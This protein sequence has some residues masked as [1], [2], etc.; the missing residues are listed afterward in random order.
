M[1][2]EAG[3]P[4]GE[5]AAAPRPSDPHRRVRQPGPA[6]AER[7]DSVEGVAERFEVDLPAG[8]NLIEAIRS[9]LERTS[10]TSAVLQLR[11]GGF[12]P[13]TYVMPALSMTPDHAAYYSELLSPPGLTRLEAGAVTFGLRDGGP[14]LHCHGIWI[15]ANGRRLGGHVIPDASIIAQPIA[16]TV[17]ALDGIDFVARPD[18]ETNFKIFG[19]LKKPRGALLGRRCF[20][21]RLRPN[22]DIC[23]AL[24]TFCRKNDIK[25]AALYGGVGSIIGA[26]FE[27]GK[28]VEPF[29]TEIFF[30]S[31]GIE[32]RGGHPEAS[33]DIGLVD[34]TG[35]LAEG[36]LRRGANPVLMTVELLLIE[37][38]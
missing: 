28:I 4:S 38:D 36:I 11:G 10:C 6:A 30:K 26:V 14:F 34:Y 19:P 16:A 22:Q 7:I 25:T 12:S 8:G 3:V 9:S 24:E 20:A 27:N 37:G 31:A 33:L 32:G 29:A 35:A 1:P 15:E 23:G 5:I 18:S 2:I 13:F 21:L 17:F